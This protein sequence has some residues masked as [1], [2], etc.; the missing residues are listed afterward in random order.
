M[1]PAPDHP[2]SSCPL[3]RIGAGRRPATIIFALTLACSVGLSKAAQAES[4]PPSS[5]RTLYALLLDE[6]T[7]ATSE[8][9]Q[10]K[11]AY[12]GLA[13]DA[14]WK[15][16]V[17]QLGRVSPS[18]LRTPDEKLAFWID[19]YNILAIELVIEHLPIESI[20]DIGGWFTPVWKKPAGT[21]EGRAYSLDEIEHEILRPMG[22][23]RIHAAI[24][25]ASISCPPLRR[26]PYDPSRLD[27]QLEDS[28]R[29]WLSN[30]NKGARLDRE[31]GILHL[32]RVF[33]WFADDFEEL[34]GV[35]VFVALHLSESD[36]RWLHGSAGKDVRI[37]YMPYDWRLN[38]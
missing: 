30:P 37:E 1:L 25:C 9:V 17:S 34:G 21:I 5:Y 8:V 12:D 2:S 28:L 23:P 29:V 36:R 6:Y 3:S 13:R 7:S 10:V 33:D 16:V 11:V 26:E 27:A 20:K 19:A 14:R 22:E 35:R 24:V 15:Q 4:S 38:D 32:S 31:A 18:E